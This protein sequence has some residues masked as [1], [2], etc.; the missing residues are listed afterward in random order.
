[1]RYHKIVLHLYNYI[2]FT[3]D[4]IKDFICFLTLNYK[5]YTFE[6]KA[7]KNEERKKKNKGG[8]KRN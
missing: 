6:R 2:T 7:I 1:M 5:C 8:E 3:N 4:Y